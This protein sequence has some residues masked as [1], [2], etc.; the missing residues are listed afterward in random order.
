M[1]K[2]FG[3]GEVREIGTLMS[4]I[5]KLDKNEKGKDENQKLYRGMIGS[6]FFYC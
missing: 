1:L 3:M 2:K 4:P 5:T 6:L